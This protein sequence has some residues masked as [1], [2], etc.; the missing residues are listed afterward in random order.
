MKL[1]KEMNNFNILFVILIILIAIFLI[2][3]ADLLIYFLKLINNS[4]NKKLFTDKVIWITGASSGLG[5]ELANDFSRLG[6]QVI[7][8]ARRNDKLLE[9][10]NK[11]MNNNSNILQPFILPLD[12]TNLNKQQEAVDIILKQFHKIDIM[13]LN[14]G[15]SQRLLGINTSYNIF[16]EIMFLN[17][18]SVVHLTQ[19]VLPSMLNRKQGQVN[20]L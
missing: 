9:V 14:A 10:K 8:S 11:I 17:F 5:A 16:E 7:L 20:T 13:I 1:K 4:Q 2:S 19:L 12:V 6:A 15:K 3:D 18:N